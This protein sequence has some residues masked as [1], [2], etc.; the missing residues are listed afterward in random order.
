MA[1][2]KQESASVTKPSSPEMQTPRPPAIIFP[3][4][5]IDANGGENDSMDRDISVAVN[6][7]TNLRQERLS[8][9]R[10]LEEQAAARLNDQAEFNEKISN[11]NSKCHEMGAHY[12]TLYDVYRSVYINH[13][14]LQERYTTLSANREE[15]KSLVKALEIQ[16]QRADEEAAAQ[17]KTIKELKENIDYNETTLSEFKECMEEFTNK[18]DKLKTERDEL[19][20][21]RNTLAI[22]NEKDTVL[23]DHLKN[24]RLEMAE[25]QTH[26]VKGLE[27]EIQ[28]LKVILERVKIELFPRYPNMHDNLDNIREVLEE[29]GH[30]LKAKKRKRRT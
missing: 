16:I 19:E 2:V 7:L 12:Q 27:S 11:M 5:P 17:E 30:T 28:E 23:I 26:T 20:T 24:D 22:K 13:H 21:E 10:K 6:T 1:T 15:E 29:D 18:L 9:V 3:P 4:P 8:L 14:S 25:F